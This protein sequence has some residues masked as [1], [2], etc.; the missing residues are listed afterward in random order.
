VKRMRSS[1]KTT[2][3]GG[4]A[5]V[6]AAP[7]LAG[8]GAT[9]LRLSLGPTA[10][11]D[12]RVGFESSLAIGIGTPL[13]FDGRSHHFAQGLASLGG[14]Y[15]GKTRAGFVGTSLAADY[16]YFAEP[17]LL[18]RAGVPLTLRL[19]PDSTAEPE[20][21]G[22]G[23]HVA[24]MPVVAGSFGGPIVGLFCLGPDLRVERVADLDGGP[25][26][27][28]FSLPFVAELVTLIAGD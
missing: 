15:D 10:D 20:L 28:R 1:G 24:L 13:S 17:H 12:E 5:V 16:I 9:T 19:A 22:V 27:A 7:L 8:C 18:V 25:A 2:R 21:F 23:A 14:G 11:T 26:R 4:L 3:L 6:F